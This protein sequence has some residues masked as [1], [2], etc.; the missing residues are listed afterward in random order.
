[1]AL[2]VVSVPIDDIITTTQISIFKTATT[3]TFVLGVTCLSFYGYLVLCRTP[4]F[5]KDFK[6]ILLAYVF[7]SFVFQVSY[8]CLKPLLLQPFNVIYP[9]GYEAPMN[10]LVSLCIYFFGIAWSYAVMLDSLLLIILERTAM[11]SFVIITNILIFPIV[12]LL[13]I[14]KLPDETEIRSALSSEIQ[15]FNNYLSM[16]P[17]LV[18]MPRS[19]NNGIFKT[20]LPIAGVYLAPRILTFSLLVPASICQV[21]VLRSHSS[22]ASLRRLNIMT[23]VIFLQGTEILLFYAAPTAFVLSTYVIDYGHH[24]YFGFLCTMLLQMGTFCPVIDFFIM[25]FFITPYREAILGLFRKRKITPNA[26]VLPQF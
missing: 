20:L 26:H 22:T 6:K 21:R 8:A 16:Q 13:V 9:V 4:H 1:M 17:S 2:H 10:K 18:Y 23:K 7:A 15:D 12:V 5:M 3:V 11:Y 14:P 25:V 24:K 19:D